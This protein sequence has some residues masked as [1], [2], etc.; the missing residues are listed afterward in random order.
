MK[1][2]LNFCQPNPVTMHAAHLPGGLRAAASGR[3]AVLLTNNHQNQTMK[4][5]T[6]NDKSD[7][8]V[9]VFEE[10]SQQL[11]EHAQRIASEVNRL[12]GE[13]TQDGPNVNER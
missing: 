8:A 7:A 5:Q 9:S 11:R 10:S 13:P 1:Q 4:T 2:F 6:I 3:L 12:L